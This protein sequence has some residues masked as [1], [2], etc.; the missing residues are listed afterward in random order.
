RAAKRARVAKRS[1]SK[2]RSSSGAVA[3]KMNDQ[4]IE[5]KFEVDAAIAGKLEQVLLVRPGAK[6]APKP[7]ALISAYYDT[8]DCA[9]MKAGFGLRV[10]E[11]EGRRIQTL[12]AEQ[13]GLSVR[14]E[15]ET[16]LQGD[17]LDLK[18]LNG[19]LKPVFATRV[20]R[21]AYP[22]RQGR[23][24][25]EAALDRGRVE[26]GDRTLEVCEL[27]LELKGGPHQGLYALAKR[28]SEAAP[29]R[30]SF[31]SKA[32]RGYRLLSGQTAGE[33]IK[34]GRVR[35]QAGMSTRDA[36]QAIA[37]SALRQWAGNA[38]VLAAVRRPE[39]LHQMRV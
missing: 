23:T 29:L 38:G 19:E 8:A 25:I 11:V 15:W 32:E 33:A 21:T 34:Q 31:V 2:A 14:G 16:E 26:A 3:H 37:A 10:R 12:K 36:F 7:K 24:K 13:A 30:L 27:E 22:V 18:G 1:R 35:L 28:L 6:A 17:G 5:L 39:A 4:E 9:L 20:E